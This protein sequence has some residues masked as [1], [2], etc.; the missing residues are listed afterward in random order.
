M[1]N[2]YIN[3]NSSSSFGINYILVK[4][5]NTL[6]LPKLSWK[7]R[8]FAASLWLEVEGLELELC[9]LAHLFPLEPFIL[10]L[11]FPIL[12]SLCLLLLVQYKLSKINPTNKSIN[13]CIHK[14]TDRTKPHYEKNMEQ[15]QIRRLLFATE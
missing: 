13:T 15:Q 6:S 8:D 12:I 4:N 1:Q 14:N 5:H 3:F 10:C 11:N 2:Q 7:N 9:P